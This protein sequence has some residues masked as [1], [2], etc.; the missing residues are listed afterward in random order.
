MA[1]TIFLSFRS[2]KLRFALPRTRPTPLCC[3]FYD[4][5][6]I[7]K[8]YHLRLIPTAVFPA[9]GNG[10]ARAGA[11]LRIKRHIYTLFVHI[12]SLASINHRTNHVQFDLQNPIPHGPCRNHNNPPNTP[13]N[14]PP[15][16][17]RLRHRPTSLQTTR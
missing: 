16:L 15:K 7:K 14:P 4:K 8:G 2:C 9:F 17:P 5:G 6:K 12:P 10:F 3:Q 11:F 13:R 1:V